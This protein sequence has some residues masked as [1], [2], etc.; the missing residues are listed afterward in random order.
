MY[1]FDELKL[2]IRIL[3]NK[4]ILIDKFKTRAHQRKNNKRGLWYLLSSSWEQEKNKGWIMMKRK[5]G[6]LLVKAE[7]WRPFLVSCALKRP[8]FLYSDLQRW[9][10]TDDLPAPWVVAAPHSQKQPGRVLLVPQRP[11]TVPL[12]ARQ[13]YVRTSSRGLELHG[14]VPCPPIFHGPQHVQIF[15]QR[16]QACSLDKCKGTRHK[17]SEAVLPQTNAFICWASVSLS[18]K[19]GK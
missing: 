18:I 2:K 8:V 9:K 13:R 19:W 16:F 7:V 5:S 17:R 3:L 4:C 15:K 12:C 1:I 11:V 10:N 6:I 14:P